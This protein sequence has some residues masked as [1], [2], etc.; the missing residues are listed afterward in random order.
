M[1]NIKNFGQFLNEAAGQGYPSGVVVNSQ[2]WKNLVKSLSSL[3]PKPSSTYT[4]PKT[5]DQNI[6]F[7]PP[8]AGPDF[9]L[10]LGSGDQMTI[11]GGYA[12][13]YKRIQ[14]SSQY[15]KGTP[16]PYFMLVF[17]NS[18]ESKMESVLGETTSAFLE[19]EKVPTKE[20]YMRFNV[21]YDPTLPEIVAKGIQNVLNAAT[22]K[23]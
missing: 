13:S 5:K 1:K 3:N 18:L 4:D 14:L 17:T 21:L 15:P 10:S 16:M 8:A 9:G 23:A 19:I 7:N 12:D 20:S 2:E 11:G 6:N 22:G